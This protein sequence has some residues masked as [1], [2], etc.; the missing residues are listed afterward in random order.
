MGYGVLD[1]YAAVLKASCVSSFTD[2]TV[3][4]DKT[5]YGCDVLD[6]ENVQVSNNSKLKLISPT[7]VT[8]NGPFTIE[9]GSSL[10]VK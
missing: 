7:K 4:S 10:D 2:Q 5:I 8:I 9:Y 3:T 6:V 1:A